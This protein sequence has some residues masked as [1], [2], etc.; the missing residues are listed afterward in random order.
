M[1]TKVCSACGRPEDAETFELLAG[2]PI[3]GFCAAILR[4]PLL[5]VRNIALEAAVNS[6]IEEEP[7]ESLPKRL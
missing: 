6:L 7:N 3:C 5:N 2:S 1:V 4:E